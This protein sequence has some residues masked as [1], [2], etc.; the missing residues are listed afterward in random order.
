[1]KPI[2]DISNSIIRYT[3]AQGRVHVVQSPLQVP[4]EFESTIRALGEKTSGTFQVQETGS[5]EQ[6]FRTIADFEGYLSHLNPYWDGLSL[7]GFNPYS[8]ILGL[9]AGVCLMGTF[10]LACRLLKRFII[11]RTL[12][13]G[14]S[15]GM[16]CLVVAALPHLSEQRL[17]SGL[18][19]QIEKFQQDAAQLRQASVDLN[20][21]VSKS[22]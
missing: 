9:V 11:L 5:A 17:V 22:F 14:G 3:D 19:G 7:T 18:Q 2:I 4:R 1:M 20:G 21:N 10:W 15:I 6:A 13:I 12:V 8:W 16:V